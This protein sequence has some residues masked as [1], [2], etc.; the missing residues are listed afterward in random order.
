[1]NT[2]RRKAIEKITS[3]LKTASSSISSLIDDETE[4]FENLPEGLQSGDKGDAMQEAIQNLESAASAVEEAISNLEEA[5][6]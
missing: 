4:A 2:E 1:M 6:A 5:S 3:L